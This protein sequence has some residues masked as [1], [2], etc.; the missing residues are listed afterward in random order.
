MIGVRAAHVCL[1]LRGID[2]QHG[3]VFVLVDADDLRLHVLASTERHLAATNQLLSH[4]DAMQSSLLHTS[5]RVPPEAV[6]KRI[7][8]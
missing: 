5:E 7:S 3:E 1:H 6:Q 2:R 4:H 8:P